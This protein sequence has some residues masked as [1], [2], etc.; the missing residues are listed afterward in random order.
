MVQFVFAVKY[1]EGLLRKEIRPQVFGVIGNLITHNDCKTLIVNGVE[2]HVHRLVGIKPKISCFELMKN[3]KALSSKHIN[4]HGL[5]KHRFEW[6]IGFG[7]LS[8][9]ESSL[10]N[11]YR[12]IANQE[13][14]H[15][16]IKFKE[17]Y[18]G[19]LKE[20]QIDYDDSYIFKDPI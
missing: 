4:D 20:F 8:Y 5:T 9:S 6:Q 14:H 3:V 13:E 11:V 12:Y 2:D 7:V 15:R 1:R 17:E 19:L 10:D 18:L 16:K